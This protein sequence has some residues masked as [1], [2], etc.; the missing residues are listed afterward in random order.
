M[1]QFDKQ[2]Y[3]ISEVAEIIGVTQ[4]TLR[5]WEKEFSAYLKPMRSGTNIRRY[6]PR[7]IERLRIIHYLL[8]VKGLRVEAAKEALRTNPANL[9]V[10]VEVLSDLREVRT[11]LADMLHAISGRKI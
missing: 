9:S 5:F 4:P 1:E 3:K 8:K 10:K 7:D 2:Y 11:Q 6:R